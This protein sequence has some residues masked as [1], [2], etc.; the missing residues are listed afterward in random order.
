[1]SLYTSV[2]LQ[3]ES[4]ADIVRRI[5]LA[6]EISRAK[7]FGCSHYDGG[8]CTGGDYCNIESDSK[9]CCVHCIY[10][11]NGDLVTT[12]GDLVATLQRNNCPDEQGICKILEKVGPKLIEKG[13]FW[14]RLNPLNYL[15]YLMSTEM[16]ELP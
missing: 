12:D 7:R 3:I 2:L 16:S 14:Q 4:E 1:M 6:R 9:I 10:S 15:P 5:L 8:K 13:S 11:S